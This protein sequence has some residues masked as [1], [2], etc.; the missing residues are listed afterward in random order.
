[1][2]D[3]GLSIIIPNYNGEELLDRFLPSVLKAVQNVA[4][5]TEILVVDDASTDSSLK[6]LR[7]FP[8]VRLIARN[9]NGGFSQ[10]CNTGISSARYE[11]LLLL[12]TDVKLE[13]D[14][15]CHFQHHF[16][17]E[18]VFAITPSAYDL[19]SGRQIDGGKYGFWQYGAPRTT[20]NYFEQE[21]EQREFPKPYPS[22]SVPG[23][24]FFCDATKMRRMGGFDPLFSPFLFED[25]DL[26]YRALKRGWKIIYEPLLRAHHLCSSTLS[27]VIRPFG[28]KVVSRRNRMIFVLVNIHSLRL[29][30]SFFFFLCLR[31]LVL[32]RAYWAGVW[33][34]VPLLPRI[35][36]RRQEERE[37]AMVSDTTLFRAYDWRQDSPSGRFRVFRP[38]TRQTDGPQDG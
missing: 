24:Y 3:P 1:M 17:D 8:E 11:I 15:L 26:S 12:N 36:K 27:K 9:T 19:Q 2:G 13:P 20:K 35:W 5:A 4:F 29:L 18:Q 16:Q 10:A 25:I 34:V 7:G 22:F 6:V 38:E 32:N 28:M 30:I 21:A 37:W 14:F 31:L 33:Q 23:A